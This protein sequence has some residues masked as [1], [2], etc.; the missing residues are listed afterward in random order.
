MPRN[1]NGHA[2]KRTG[3]D[4]E[5]V[6]SVMNAIHTEF[7]VDA[8][9][10]VYVALDGRLFAEACCDLYVSGAPTVH[11]SAGAFA[12]GRSEELMSACL[13]ALHR[14]YHTIDRVEG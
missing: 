11:L 8:D 1:K 3:P 14:L 2:Q 5:D 7:A 9:L 4:T 10:H 13:I 12:G 6:L